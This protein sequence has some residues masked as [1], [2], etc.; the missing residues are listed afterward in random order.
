VEVEVIAG[1]E[2]VVEAQSIELDETRDLMTD[3][4]RE[5]KF[6]LR[7]SENSIREAVI[8]CLIK[9]EVIIMVG[10][11]TLESRGRPNITPMIS[12]KRQ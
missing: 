3:T 5:H 7:Q 2:A 11:I 12:E 10:K 6:L 4:R 1:V 9:A 8:I